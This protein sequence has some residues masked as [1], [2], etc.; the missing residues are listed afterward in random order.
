MSNICA[1]LVSLIA[2]SKGGEA[3]VNT[4]EM[5]TKPGTIYERINAAAEQI[6]EARRAQS[7]TWW[8]NRRLWSNHETWRSETEAEAFENIFESCPR[9]PGDPLTRFERG[10]NAHL[11]RTVV[12]AV[13]KE[14][15]DS[16]PRHRRRKPKRAPV[17]ARKPR[18][19][20]RV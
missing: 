5:P 8:Q 7:T 4:K 16:A 18:G 13:L 14:M 9:R 2:A 3:L 12:H 15:R 10:E 17:P 19:S 6:S 1:I 20:K 11:M